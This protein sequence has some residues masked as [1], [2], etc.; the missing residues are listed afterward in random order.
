MI[1]RAYGVALALPAVFAALVMVTSAANGYRGRG[2]TILSEREVRVA[3]RTRDR[4]VAELWLEWTEPGGMP[5]AWI[6]PAS[7]AALGF[8][9]S[10]EVSDPRADGHYRRQLSRRAFVAFELN[11]P[12]WEAAVADR[13]ATAPE[14]P[15]E[16]A[17]R[18]RIL[19]DIRSYGSRLVPVAVDVDAAALAQRYSDARTHLITAGVVRIARF[20]RAG[21]LPYLGG[22]LANIN[23]RR[24][25][26][27]AAHAAS[28]P[29]RSTVEG[30]AESGYT[31]SVMYGS[32][33]EPWVVGIERP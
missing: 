16:P 30:L 18:N 7:L 8:D 22:M 5:G 32:R 19:P 28:L 29:V 25:Q 13:A 27:P 9:V 23:P 31:V 6:T 17:G 11:G 4:S 14:P 24:I 1:P 33:W 20:E 2:P 10:V 15:P 12:A 26:V 21:G 3:P